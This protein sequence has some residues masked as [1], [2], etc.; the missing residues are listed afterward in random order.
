M[1]HQL[2]TP[3]NVDHFYPNDPLLETVR[4]PENVL[5]TRT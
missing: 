3:E 5:Q 1:K 4:A 2:I